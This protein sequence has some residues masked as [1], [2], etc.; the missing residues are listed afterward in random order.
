MSLIPRQLPAVP[1]SFFARWIK[2]ALNV[3]RPRSSPTLPNLP[4]EESTDDQINVDMSS[5]DVWMRKWCNDNPTKS[6]GEAA[7]AFRDQMTGRR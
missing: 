3:A 2:H 7:R 4:H 1:M 6:V 5:L